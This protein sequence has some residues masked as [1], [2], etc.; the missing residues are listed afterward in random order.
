MLRI[1]NM[2]IQSARPFASDGSIGSYK[3]M[4]KLFIQYIK[5]KVDKKK[6]M[7]KAWKIRLQ[8]QQVK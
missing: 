5:E 4:V 6:W 8:I 3:H 1:G 2:I 7:Q